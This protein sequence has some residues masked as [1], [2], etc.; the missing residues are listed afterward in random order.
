MSFV[1]A[2]GSQR[3]PDAAPQRR[4]GRK[5]SQGS[6]PYHYTPILAVKKGVIR[7]L[8]SVM[9]PT[10]NCAVYLR[11]T[12]AS[13]LV[14]DPGTHLMQIEVVDDCSTCDDPAKVVEELGL[15]R[16]VFYR[17]PKN[18]GYIRNFE[19]CLQRSRGHLIHL[20]H[21]DDYVREGFYRQ[22][23]QGF[24]ASPEIG[25]AFCRTIYVDEQGHWHSISQLEQPESG[26]LSDW[27]PKI[28]AG[29]RVCTPSVVV[30]RGV[31]EEIGGF[32][33][34]LSC[35]GE[36]WEMW[37]RIATRYPFWFEVEPLAAYR[38]KRPSS[39]T[40]GSV[41]TGALARDMRKATE[42]V[43]SY[44]PNYLS[45]AVAREVSSK[46]RRM[47]A[48]WAMEVVQQMPVKGNLGSFVAQIKE[49]LRC[50]HS[51][52]TVCWLFF[53]LLQ[54]AAAGLLAQPAE[55]LQR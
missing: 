20:L 17:Q 44:L 26:V 11:R 33:R 22:L 34:R 9:I 55:R 43:E 18:Q 41:S 8:W 21:G 46:A 28:A 52:K 40:A 42:I 49:V 48:Q 2:N 3:S 32:D 36:D 10:Y 30:R 16:V 39:L 13:V 31:Y 12:L 1:I 19:T 15:G 45:P 14:Q 4:A 7:P 53:R 37:V 54:R 47:Y 29:Q 23:Q 25:A 50:S 35:A 38:M 5:Y 6:E 51:P 24:D 27:L